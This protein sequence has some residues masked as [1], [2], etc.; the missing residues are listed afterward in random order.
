[1]VVKFRPV[2]MEDIAVVAA[3]MR[4]IDKMELELAGGLLPYVALEQSV[5]ASVYCRSIDVDG[6]AVAIFGVCKP[7]ILSSNGTVWLLGSQEL[8][9]IKKSFVENSLK[10]INEGFNYVDS[11][12]NYVWIEN[13]LS[14]RWLKWC[15]FKFDEPA[16]YGLKHALFLHFYKEKEN[17]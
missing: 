8:A 17:V 3:K 14:I 2:K 12:E 10:Y 16:P 4:D 9:K 7:F 15:G 13:K 11:L 6:E 1:M 5:Q